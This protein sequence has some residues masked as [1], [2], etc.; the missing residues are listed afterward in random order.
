[1]EAGVTVKQKGLENN[2][3]DLIAADEVFDVTR[4][5]LESYM[6]PANYVGRSVEQTEAFLANIVKPILEANRDCLGIT[7]EI[8][9]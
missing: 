7:A 4:E 6:V 9:V 2:L 3:L 1:M 8:N 5:E